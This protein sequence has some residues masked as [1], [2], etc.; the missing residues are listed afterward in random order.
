MEIAMTEQTHGS[1]I[2]FY[3]FKGGTGRTM[4]LANAAWILA[5]AGY[6]VLVVD[7]DLESPGLHRFFEPFLDAGTIAGN[8]GV[9]DMIRDYAW[10]VNLDRARAL[11]GEWLRAQ[12]RV[13]PHVVP[14]DW[15]FPA[16]G[17]LDFVSA[18]RQNQ[19]Y[20]AN[21]ASLDWDN[22]YDRLGGGQ[23]FDAMRE[24]MRAEYDYTLIDSR[25]GVSDVS[26]IC[27]V[28]L[29]DVLVTCF[30]LSNQGIF[31]AADIVKKIDSQ[32]SRTVR[33]LPVP[34]R[35]DEGEKEKADMG[36]RLARAE[37]ESL[38][39][40]MSADE[41]TEYWGSV[42]IPYR[43]FYAYEE[44]LAAFGDEPGVANS[45]LSAF[46]RLV[47]YITEGTVT[48]YAS[49][50][51]VERMRVLAAFTR[52][53]VSE[54]AG[55]VLSF[56]PVDR[57]WA[58][59]IEETLKNAGVR[60]RRFDPDAGIE[61]LER[62][63]ILVVGSAAYAQSATYRL[64]KANISTDFPAGVE[65]RLT[66]ANVLGS[67]LGGHFGT[68][69]IVDLNGLAE[70]RAAEALLRMVDLPASSVRPGPGRLGPRFPGNTPSVFEVPQRNPY[71]TGRDASLDRLR[72]LF[73]SS[74]S[75]DLLRVALHGL[76]GVG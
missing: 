27:T 68:T 57:M 58:E 29:P 13:G 20:S 54:P 40:H 62:E 35:I 47:G 60:V 50:P 72:E 22:F 10:A 6:R 66:V 42:E 23:F 43:P 49:V 34:S 63:R 18:G 11:D 45:L 19:N 5:S 74:A 51:E 24:D 75:S 71:F 16:G 26:A 14:L 46:E 70:A 39:A 2:T 55:F 61:P 4:A 69:R 12:A 53:L 38:P 76:G 36:R 9:I 8:A 17:A 67:R 25:T 1:I 33:I 65:D 56:V 59:W 30:T 44:I 15:E 32:T 64:L 73:T 37:F 41:L 31:G 7:W 3:S 21:V 48:S 52:R 28:Q